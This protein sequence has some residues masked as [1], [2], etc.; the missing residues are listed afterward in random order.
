MRQRFEHSNSGSA[1]IEANIRFP[2]ELDMTPFTTRAKRKGKPTEAERVKGFKPYVYDLL[3]VVV[4]KGEINS[5]HYINFAREGGQ[6]KP[7]HPPF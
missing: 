5:G 7:S 1:K 4:H 3:S 2:M 6:V